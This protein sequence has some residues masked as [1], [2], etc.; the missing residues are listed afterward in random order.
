M[1]AWHRGLWIAGYSR[2]VS[3]DANKVTAPARTAVSAEA[4][5]VLLGSTRAGGRGAN[6]TQSNQHVRFCDGAL[7]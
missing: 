6:A 4:V 2:L 1:Q 5:V 3:T 7:Y